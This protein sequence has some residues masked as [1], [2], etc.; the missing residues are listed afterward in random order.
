MKLI[1]ECMFPIAGKD[2]HNHKTKNNFIFD[3]ISMNDALSL[4]G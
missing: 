1:D 3:K 4:A 2:K